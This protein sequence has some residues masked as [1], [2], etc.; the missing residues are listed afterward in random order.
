M[1]S[2]GFSPSSTVAKD[3]LSFNISVV[4]LQSSKAR[5][6]F[7]AVCSRVRATLRVALP[8]AVRTSALHETNK[9]RP[10]VSQWVN[11]EWNAAI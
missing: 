4:F 1:A 8:P 6:V 9:L 5:L 7:F 10:N 3:I 11:G 2:P